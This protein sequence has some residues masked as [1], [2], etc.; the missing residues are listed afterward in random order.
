[1]LAIPADDHAPY[2]LTGVE[3][4]TKTELLTTVA[5]N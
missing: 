3:K 5:W 4:S 1:M 2:S